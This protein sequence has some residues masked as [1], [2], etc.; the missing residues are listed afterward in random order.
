MLRLLGLERR[1]VGDLG[2]VEREVK[3]RGGKLC[4]NFLAGF[5]DAK[6]HLVSCAMRTSESLVKFLGE[7]GLLGLEDVLHVARNELA[8]PPEPGLWSR[9]HTERTRDLRMV[10]HEV[11]VR[12]MGEAEPEAT[13]VAVE[14]GCCE[15]R[16][17][18]TRVTEGEGGL[19]WRR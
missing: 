7:R 11:F 5:D 9:E 8:G 14:H 12:R 15:T 13:R 17:D 4:F 18:E 10:G 6:G 19:R 1:R 2:V 3:V 16:L